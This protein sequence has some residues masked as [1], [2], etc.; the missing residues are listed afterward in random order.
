[1]LGEIARRTPLA[2][3][4]LAAAAALAACGDKT[5]DSGDAEGKIADGVKEQQNYEPEKVECPDDMKAE[6]GETYECKVTAPGGREATAKITMVDDE[7]RFRFV[8]PP[9]Q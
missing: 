3:A 8:V 1:M 6:K 5:L 7:G 4:A 2:V 9:P